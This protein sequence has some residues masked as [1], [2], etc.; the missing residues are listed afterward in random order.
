MPKQIY[1]LHD[2]EAFQAVDQTAL[3]EWL[4]EVQNYGDATW[5]EH[6]LKGL[7]S[8]FVY[9]PK[10][11]GGWHEDMVMGFLREH[12]PEDFVRQWVPGRDWQWG[13]LRPDYSIVKNPREMLRLPQRK[14]GDLFMPKNM[15]IL[16]PSY[17]FVYIGNDD[18]PYPKC[19]E[20]WLF[21][22]EGRV[23][24]DIVSIPGCMALCC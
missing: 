23:P 7:A 10:S 13:E 11:A 8:A 21:R 14:P 16:P 6:P 24:G 2:C 12:F 22:P 5:G 19:G 20:E 17:L 9:K 1:F 15:V 18:V 4:D 3:G